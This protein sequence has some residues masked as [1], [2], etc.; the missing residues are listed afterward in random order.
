MSTPLRCSSSNAMEKLWSPPISLKGLNLT[1]PIL[2]IACCIVLNFSSNACTRPA[3]SSAVISVGICFFL[4][5][6]ISLH[7]AHCNAAGEGFE[8]PVLFRAQQFSKLPHSSTLASRLLLWTGWGSN[9]QPLQCHCSA[10]PIELPA[11]LVFWC[12]REAST[13]HSSPSG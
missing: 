8:P 9:P 10:L 4:N 2:V 6:L 12:P 11:L 5:K 3:S 1:I 13:P 7:W